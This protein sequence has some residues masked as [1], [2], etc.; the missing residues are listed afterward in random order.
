MT[1]KSEYPEHERLLQ[2]QDH[3][4]SIGEFIEWLMNEKHLIFAKAHEHGAGCFDDQGR[5]ACGYLQG[6]LEY[7][8]FNSVKMLAEFWE[9]DLVRLEAEKRV[10]LDKIRW[11][12]K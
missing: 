7:V 8:L 6:G 10:M 5:R 2:F 12:N 9:I 11:V 3:S 1:T 4:Q